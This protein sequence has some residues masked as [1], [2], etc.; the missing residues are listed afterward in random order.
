M[1]SCL[2]GILVESEVPSAYR[3]VGAGK[4]FLL[5][6]PTVAYVVAIQRDGSGLSRGDVGD[7][8]LLVAEFGFRQASMKM[9]GHRPLAV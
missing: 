3:A 1:R 8:G 7:E 5:M 9:V 6:S 2:V 4:P